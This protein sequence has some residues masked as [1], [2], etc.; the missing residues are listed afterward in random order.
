[1]FGGTLRRLINWAVAAR[2]RFPSYRILAT[3][4]DFKSAY[5]RC[6]LNWETALTT[7]TQ[8][9]DDDIALMSLR[10]TFGGSPCPNEWGVI[11]ET[12][13]DL[14]NAILHDDEWDPS[15]LHSPSQH[16][17]PCKEILS[18]DIPFAQ[19]DELI[20]NVPF[21]DRGFVDDYIDD[22][23]GLTVD[24]PGSNNADRLERAPLLAIH[25][26]ARPIHPDE[27]IP[28]H[29]MAALNN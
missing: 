10:L 3:K 12:V 20:V 22:L 17:I 28:R 11:S 25:T 13:C 18:D 1:M 9:P 6:H 26:L 23:I 14:T 2:K 16:L 7:C 29:D 27:P 15:I 21:N 4:A 8:L 19:V 5:R 24:I